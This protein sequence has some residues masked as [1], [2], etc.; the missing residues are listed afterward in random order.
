FRYGL[1]GS[2]RA[3][4]AGACPRRPR[5]GLGGGHPHVAPSRGGRARGPLDDALDAAGLQ[6][7]VA[8]VVPTFA[9]AALLVS[10][11]CY[12][13]LVPRRFAEQYGR[14]LGIR[15]FPIS[16]ALPE[17]EV[18]LLWHARLDADPAQRWL[19]ETIC[20]AL[21]SPSADNPGGSDRSAE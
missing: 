5:W 9:V 7:H 14:T 17:L 8:A 6:R 2:A 1:G 18:R 4:R 3:Y 10:S 11:S 21:G 15:W 13:G 20:D 16:A 12:V 19:R